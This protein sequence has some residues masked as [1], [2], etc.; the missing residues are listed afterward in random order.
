MKKVLFFFLIAI[1]GLA[2]TACGSD[3]GKEKSHDMSSMEHNMDGEKMEH[4]NNL[5]VHQHD[6]TMVMHADKLFACP[7]D[8]E[9]VTSDPDA[10]C[11]K[12]EMYVKPIAEVKADYDPK[13]HELYTCS[14]HPEFI[15][16]EATDQCPICE[17]KVTKVE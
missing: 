11:P 7:M 10:S 12:C 1:L 4:K 8:A 14:M 9:Y 13:A 2:L 3:E 17:M 5:A 6:S 16:S 15:T